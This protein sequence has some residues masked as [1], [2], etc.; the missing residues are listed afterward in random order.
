MY[1]S[2]CQ[3]SNIGLMPAGE[4]ASV[5]P[6]AIANAATL[7]NVGP[8]PVLLVY[9]DNDAFTPGPNVPNEVDLVTPDILNWQTTCNCSVTASIQPNQGHLQQFHLGEPQLVSTITGWL[10]S[11]SL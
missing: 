4:L 3:N 8:T 2:F 9:G 10:T 7:S 5:A 6:M 11:R 1:N